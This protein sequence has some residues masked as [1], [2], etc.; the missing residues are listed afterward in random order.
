[1]HPW[2]LEEVG[3]HICG[4]LFRS[5]SSAL[6]TLHLEFYTLWIFSYMVIFDYA[7]QGFLIMESLGST[8]SNNTVSEP[9]NICCQSKEKSMICN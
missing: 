9:E 5:E 3:N 8:F 1:M 6:Y 4:M 7:F 2:P